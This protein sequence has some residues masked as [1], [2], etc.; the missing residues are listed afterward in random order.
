VQGDNL[1]SSNWAVTQDGQKFLVNA[2]LA[3][4]QATPFT[5]ILNWP[6][7]LTAK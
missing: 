3:T 4:S 2:A 5:V 7:T 1:A 6:E